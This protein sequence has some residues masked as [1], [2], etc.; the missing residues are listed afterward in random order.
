M[1]LPR[2]SQTRCAA[3]LGEQRQEGPEGGSSGLSLLAGLWSS[4]AICVLLSL[5]GAALASP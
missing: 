5:P 4:T 1:L 2:E 3:V